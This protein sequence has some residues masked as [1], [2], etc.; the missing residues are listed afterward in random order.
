MNPMTSVVAL[1]VN[2]LIM[3]VVIPVG[4][5]LVRAVN[6]NS[7]TQA[8]VV[9]VM[10]ELK[11]VLLGMEGQGGLARRT[12]D[13]ADRLSRLESL[14]TAVL[15]ITTELERFRNWKHDDYADWAQ[16]IEARVNILE[17]QLAQRPPDRRRGS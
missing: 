16:K 17:H 2:A 13:L 3:I 15:G 10:G 1:A 8:D 9:K 4:W 12:E 14:P 6:S 7:K 11:A 5:Y